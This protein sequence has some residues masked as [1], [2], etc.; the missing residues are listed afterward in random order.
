MEHDRI[1]ERQE[2]ISE[3]VSDISALSASYEV[4]KKDLQ[5]ESDIISALDLPPS[6][7]DR[8]LRQIEAYQEQLQRKYEENVTRPLEEQTR[9][10]QEMYGETL[11]NIENL[12]KAV[13]S[14]TTFRAQSGVSS[15][16]IEKGKEDSNESIKRHDE[17]KNY[18]Q[19]AHRRAEEEIRKQRQKIFTRVGR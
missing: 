10:R 17:M 18:Y 16:A 5:R 14:L 2:R 4:N 7:K 1:K 12:R 3:K 6:E 9:A 8:L 11:K 15:G 13:G 19:Q